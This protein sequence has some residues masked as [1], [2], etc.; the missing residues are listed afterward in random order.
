MQRNICKFKIE[1]YLHFQNLFKK[2]Y[3]Y[4]YHVQGY[5]N[6]VAEFV[7]YN[8][9]HDWVPPYKKQKLIVSYNTTWKTYNYDLF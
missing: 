5:L 2:K 1:N 9:N 8:T 3:F 6:Y 7:V 4:L